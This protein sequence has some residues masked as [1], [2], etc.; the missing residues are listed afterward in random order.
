MRL[1]IQADVIQLRPEPAK[2]LIDRVAVLTKF[3]VL[4]T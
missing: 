2:Y 3:E 4:L 1:Y